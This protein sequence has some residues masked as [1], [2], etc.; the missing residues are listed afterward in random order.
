MGEGV[1]VN[2]DGGYDGGIWVGVWGDVCDVE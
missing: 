1:Y 2:V